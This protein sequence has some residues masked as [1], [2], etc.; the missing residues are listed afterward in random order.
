MTG[1]A[2][3]EA[4]ELHEIYK[5]GVV[6]IPTNKPMIRGDQSDLIYKTE[7]AKYIA[8]V[9]DVAER[10][11]KGQPV[12]IGTTSVERSEYLSRQFQQAPH[13]AQRA[14]REVPRAGGRHHRRGRPARRD[15]R[16]HQ[17]GRPRHR[18]RARRQRRLP[19]RQA[20][21]RAGTRPGRDARGVRGR[22][23]R[24]AAAGQGRGAPRRPRRSSPPAACT[25]WAPSGTSRA[26]STTSCAAG[27]AARATRASPGSTCRSATS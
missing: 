9:D 13:P 2:Q 15:H 25:C 21:A 23:A 19:R 3:T 12:L 18:H 5:L 6:P 11:E 8:V 10:Y 7:E 24:G 17:H 1:T 16:R 26:A 22:L 4:A 27:P 20:A 14:Q